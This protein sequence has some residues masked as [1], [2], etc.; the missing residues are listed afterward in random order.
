MNR[1]GRHFPA[2]K[3]RRPRRLTQSREPVSLADCMSGDGARRAAEL[4]VDRR[5]EFLSDPHVRL[6]DAFMEFAFPAILSFE[7][8][9]EIFL[10]MAE[11]LDQLGAGVHHPAAMLRSL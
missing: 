8:E 3:L 2:R 1:V 7:R 11:G 6:A 9:V 10:H 5:P 4:F